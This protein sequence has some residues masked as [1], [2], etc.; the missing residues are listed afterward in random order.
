MVRVETANQLSDLQELLKSGG[1]KSLAVAYVSDSGLT[2]ISESLK[3]A[4]TPKSRRVRFLLGL[5][6]SGV[7]DPQAVKRLFELSS[8]YANLEVKVFIPQSG[9]E[10]FH[11]KLFISHVRNGITFL[12]GSFNLT[13]SALTR[14]REHGL[15]VTCDGSEDIGKQTL[16]VFN[17]LWEDVQARLL[18]EEVVNGYRAYCRNRTETEPDG[19]RW[20]AFKKGIPPNLGPMPTWPSSELAFLMGV[21]NARG[22]FVKEKNRVMIQLKFGTQGTFQFQGQDHFNREQS[23]RVRH[24]IMDE[25]LGC[26]PGAMAYDSVSSAGYRAGREP[27]KVCPSEVQVLFID[28][29]TATRMFSLLLKAF[30]ENA[31]ARTPPAGIIGPRANR[32]IV[33]RFLQGYAAAAGTIN[34]K[35]PGEVR[36][37]TLAKGDGGPIRELIESKTKAKSEV[38]DSGGKEYIA[39]P[40]SDFR[41]A[42]GFDEEWMDELAK[43]HQDVRPRSRRRRATTP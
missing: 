23:L 19:E 35:Y 4:L 22:T 37:N 15:K 7:T 16:Q 42:I 9:N 10:I 43:N 8:N 32:A 31:T 34:D 39:V 11:P 13:E 25:V 1:D 27:I 14:N 5:D 26:L 40:I 20:E 18:T 24:R 29:P 21:I 38:R 36:L 33:K 41:K 2:L 12:T 3:R 30:G 6:D 17:S 28:F